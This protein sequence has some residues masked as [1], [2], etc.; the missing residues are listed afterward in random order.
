VFTIKKRCARIHFGG[1]VIKLRIIELPCL[2]T[3]HFS[4]Q[5]ISTGFLEKI[6]YILKKLKRKLSKMGVLKVLGSIAKP[7]VDVKTWVGYDNLKNSTKNLAALF[8][9]VFKKPQKVTLQESFA[10]AV[11]RL[12]LTEQDLQRMMKNFLIHS[13]IYLSALSASLIY[14]LY[15]VWHAHWYAGFFMLI[16]A[17]IFCLKAAE[18]NFHHFQIKQRKLDCTFK[19][20][21]MDASIQS[22]ENK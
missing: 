1:A 21:L 5:K 15:L 10:E 17:T 20:W 4:N 19:Q 7:S 6:C 22:E 8:K 16:I 18:A 3:V 13:Y 11:E 2:L 9:M 14:M 12:N